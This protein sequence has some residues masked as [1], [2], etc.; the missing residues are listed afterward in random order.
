MSEGGPRKRIHEAV[1]A[2]NDQQDELDD[3]LL[4][5]WVLVAEWMDPEGDR[6]L[7]KVS[8]TNGGEDSPNS[9]TERG[10]LHEV[11]YHWLKGG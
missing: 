11:L 4:V 3:A 10:Y 6:W 9:W 5:G 2:T 7:S 1:Q 8:G